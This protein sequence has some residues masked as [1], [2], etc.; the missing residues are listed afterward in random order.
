MRASSSRTSR[1]YAGTPPAAGSERDDSAADLARAR[2]RARNTNVSAPDRSTRT[3]RTSKEPLRPPVTAL[4]R[5]LELPLCTIR[6][7][8]VWPERLLSISPSTSMRPSSGLAFSFQSVP[9]LQPPSRMTSSSLAEA[10]RA[11]N[12]GRSI[13]VVMTAARVRVVCV[14]VGPPSGWP[15]EWR[16]YEGARH[17]PV[18]LGPVDQSSQA[19]TGSSLAQA[20]DEDPSLPLEHRH[21]VRHHEQP[22]SRRPRPS[23]RRCWSPRSPRVRA[24]STPSRR[25][26]CR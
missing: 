18:V 25:A 6:Q 3:R 11:V 9:P 2:L 13:A 10:G 24:G 7:R 22:G 14:M 26:A 17:C 1:Q 4:P 23:G 5:A 19:Q 16:H 15:P 8:Q 20:V 12:K 21:V